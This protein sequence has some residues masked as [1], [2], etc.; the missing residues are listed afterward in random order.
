M[1]SGIRNRAY[2][3]GKE[4]NRWVAAVAFVFEVGDSDGDVTSYLNTL[5]KRNASLLRF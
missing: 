3:Y 1:F 4:M 5:K 2:V